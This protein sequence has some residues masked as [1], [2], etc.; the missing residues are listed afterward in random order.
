MQNEPNLKIGKMHLRLTL[1]RI[2]EDFCAFEHQKNEPNSNPICSELA[3]TA[4]TELVE[5]SNLFMKTQHVI[6]TGLPWAQSKG[7][8]CLSRTKSKGAKPKGAKRNPEICF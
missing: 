6:S 1:T 3:C 2:Y 5:V 4:C 7:L 8:P